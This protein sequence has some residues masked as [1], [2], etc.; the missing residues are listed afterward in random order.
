MLPNRFSFIHLSLQIHL[1]TQDICEIKK[2]LQT[3]LF[4]VWMCVAECKYSMKPSQF[5][6]LV[7]TWWPTKLQ[8]VTFSMSLFIWK[9]V[10]EIQSP[11]MKRNPHINCM[12]WQN[13]VNDYHPLTMNSPLSMFS[14]ALY[15]TE[16]VLC[17]T[18]LWPM[19]TSH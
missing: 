9:N 10:Y 14:A 6:H 19:T 3:E 18:A 1:C 2:K 12:V 4:T 8:E 13:A 15:G 5:N 11:Y 17:C 7:L 16:I